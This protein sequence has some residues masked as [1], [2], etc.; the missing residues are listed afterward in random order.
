MLK[1]ISNN[2]CVDIGEIRERKTLAEH[3]KQAVDLKKIVLHSAFDRCFGSD[4][5]RSLLSLFK[6]SNY[7]AFIDSLIRNDAVYN[8][9]P[10]N[11][12]ALADRDSFYR[13]RA[14]IPARIKTM[15]A[16]RQAEMARH[17]PARKIAMMDMVIA[18]SEETLSQSYDKAIS[19]STLLRSWNDID[20]AGN[21][22]DQACYKSLLR[23]EGDNV[24][25]FWSAI[26]QLTDYSHLFPQARLE[27]ENKKW[28]GIIPPGHQ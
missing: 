9:V 17:A 25:N 18:R 8:G 21:A 16:T 12:M 7:N 13:D 14:E 22:L 23:G 4:K 26:H 19:L 3:W 15:K 5:G 20:P 6:Q 1:T 10:V 11:A 28:T 27:T 24:V 2:I